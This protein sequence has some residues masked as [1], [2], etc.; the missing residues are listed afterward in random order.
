M[1]DRIDLHTA[2][3]PWL[4]PLVDRIRAARAA[5]NEEEAARLEQYGH[6]EGSE[7]LSRM[8]G[9][10]LALLDARDQA[11]ARGE[12]MEPFLVSAAEEG[13]L[14]CDFCTASN[15][16]VYYPVTEFIIQAPGGGFL[17]G[18]RFYACP[19]CRELIDADDWKGLRDWIGPAQFG[20]GHRLLVMG[21]KQHRA[22][23]PVEFEPGTN[24]ES[25]R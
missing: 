3:A 24:P 17:S 20:L 14:V 1:S 19:R 13:Q 9:Q 12:E 2:D 7:A 16:A 18:D 21:F 23:E 10:I 4:R 25:G 8:L 6:S 22:G 11:V 15:P 5:G